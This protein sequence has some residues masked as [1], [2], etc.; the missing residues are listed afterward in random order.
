MQTNSTM[1]V[2]LG[3]CLE[4]LACGRKNTQPI[5]SAAGSVCTA[6]CGYAV[7]CN[8]AGCESDCNTKGLTD[9]KAAHWKPEFVAAV[10]ACLDRLTCGSNDTSCFEQ[11]LAEIEPGYQNAPEVQR[12]LGKRS[13]CTPSWADDLCYSISALV[14]ADRAASDA[15]S[16]TAECSEFKHCMAP[17]GGFYY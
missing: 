16:S 13:S 17:Y 11:A 4:C 2:A 8:L 1:V 12:C 3:L 6:L 7:R 5:D 9:D 10:T 14:P 15:C